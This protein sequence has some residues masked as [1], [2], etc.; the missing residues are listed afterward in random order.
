MYSV[1][2]LL[3]AFILAFISFSTYAQKTFLYTSL[4]G[5]DKV[6]VF[7]IDQS[8]GDLSF[9]YDETVVGQPASIAINTTKRLFYIARRSA[10][11]I[12]S[13]S[14]DSVTGRLS[15]IN[16]IDALDNPVYISLDRSGK[17]LLSAYFAAN[18]AG[19][20][21]INNDGS[22][23]SG[24]IQ[25][26]TTGTNPH[27][28]I[29]DPANEFMYV[30]NMTG[31]RIEQYGFNQDN[32]TFAPL[33]PFAIIPPEN[34]CPRHLVFNQSGN[35]LY[36]VNEVGNKVTVYESEI[37]TGQL[38]P[39]QSL[40]TLPENFSG[41]N[42]C[43]DIHITPD[44]S[45]LYASNR[46]D[47]SIVAYKINENDGL[48]T[49]IDWY[50]TAETPRE[51][52]IGPSGKYLF[53]A[54]ETSNDIISYGIQADGSLDSLKRI[55]VGNSPSW[56]STVSFVNDKETRISD[57]SLH[58]ESIIVYPNPVK[59]YLFIKVPIDDAENSLL[60]EIYNTLGY[61]IVNEK[62]LLL[63]PGINELN[64]RGLIPL[65]P[66]QLSGLYYCVLSHLHKRKVVKLMI[67]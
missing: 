45:Y 52:D 30:T 7:E 55:I 29:T 38:N 33:D 28:I 48:L 65:D 35:R 9:I 59:E 1:K 51:F 47:E 56:V 49:L 41:T 53:V 2:K 12:S 14:I 21:G 31:N 60:I 13:Y 39:L 46:G 54:G 6:S 19:V 40:S 15:F 63:N 62:E 3:Y 26:V 34:D 22:L 32:G 23:I 42:K 27:A 18:E 64:L 11:K 43:A 4:K 20:Y 57:Y 67:Q 58:P 66:N 44:G 16:E 50:P 17:F 61:V 24:V 10:H 37:T 5:E 8:T 25:E 36:V